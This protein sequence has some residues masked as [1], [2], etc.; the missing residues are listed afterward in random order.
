ML[1]VVRRL[2][3]VN[4]SRFCKR[5]A[6]VVMKCFLF[7]IFVEYIMYIGFVI[8]LDWCVWLSC[9]IVLFVFYGSFIVTCTRRRIFFAF[10]DACN[11]ILVL[12]VFE[13]MVICLL[14]FINVFFLVMFI[15]SILLLLLMFVFFLDVVV[16]RDSYMS[17][18][19]RRMMWL[20]FFVSLVIFVG[21]L[22]LL[23]RVLRK[24]G[25]NFN[26]MI[27]LINFFLAFTSF[28]SILVGVFV[29]KWLV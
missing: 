26:L 17:L 28:S 15:L 1:V 6:T 8:W 19:F 7:L 5:R 10:F 27:L 24:F 3:F 18:S 9:W 4:V 12:V 13:I 23:I 25:G 21:F 2:F 16:L 22:S 29:W 14:L 11:E 20:F